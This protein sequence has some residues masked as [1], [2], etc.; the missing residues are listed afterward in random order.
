MD[1]ENLN[2]L[3]EEIRKSVKSAMMEKAEDIRDNI[4][5]AVESVIE[6]KLSECFSRAIDDCISTH[7]FVLQDGT[8]I[9]TRQKTKVLSPDKK[10]LLTC[11]GDVEVVDTSN[12]CGRKWKHWALVV[13]TGINSKESL[14]EYDDEREATEALMKLSDAMEQGLSL[15]EL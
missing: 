11:Y 13:Q 2:E 9:K 10:K 7:R 1:I 3:K 14:C 12:W 15:I 5:D 6:D 8:E 4:C